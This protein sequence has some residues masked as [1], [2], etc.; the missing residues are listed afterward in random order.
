M[1]CAPVQV[2]RTM[3]SKSPLNVSGRTSRPSMRMSPE[4]IG[5]PATLAAVGLFAMEP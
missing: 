1:A 4:V 2:I 3:P 5:N